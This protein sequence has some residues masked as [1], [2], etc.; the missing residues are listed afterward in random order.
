M[1]KVVKYQKCA[2]LVN[3]KLGEMG[4]VFSLDARENTTDEESHPPCLPPLMPDP[5]H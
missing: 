3:A 4:N 1:E 2:N 5:A